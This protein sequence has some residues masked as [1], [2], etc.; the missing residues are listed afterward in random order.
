MLRWVLLIVAV[1]SGCAAAW[2]AIQ[3][4][5]HHAVAVAE[6]TPAPKLPMQDVLVASIEL[7]QAQPLSKE[8]MHWQ[9]WP[10]HAIDPVYI[11]RSEQ[12]DALETLSGSLVRTRMGPGEPIREENLAPRN[13]G[14]LAAILPSGKRAVAVRISVENTAGG[15]ILPTDRVDVLHTDGQASGGEE[16]TSRTILRNIPVLAIDQIVD[17]KKKDEK[18]KASV[19]GKTATLEVDSVQAE[20][21]IAA[22]AR[23]TLSLSLRSAADNDD[24]SQRSWRTPRIIR[25]GRAETAVRTN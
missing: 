1:L 23:G 14:F 6:T 21:L 24:Y 12:P 9:S 2:L 18:G 8:S 5:P 4:R 10:E 22:Q 15:F 3:L 16:P 19:I 25:A 17:E 11:T 13:K 20:I 7:R